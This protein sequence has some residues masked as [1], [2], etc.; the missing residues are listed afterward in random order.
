MLAIQCLPRDRM[1][2]LRIPWYSSNQIICVGHIF[3]LEHSWP[4]CVGMSLPSLPP[5]CPKHCQDYRGWVCKVYISAGRRM[6]FSQRMD[7]EGWLKRRVTSSLSH[8]LP[9]CRANKNL[10]EFCLSPE[11]SKH[12]Q[13]I[14]M[15]T[16]SISLIPTT[17]HTLFSDNSIGILLF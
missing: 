16:S 14:L 7:P 1:I 2:L 12:P 11:V 3:H 15:D 8:I 10:G 4:M 5:A 13:I 6:L 9:K 17:L